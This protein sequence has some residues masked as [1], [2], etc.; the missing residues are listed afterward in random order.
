MTG[1]VESVTRLYGEGGVKDYCITPRMQSAEAEDI[2]NLAMTTNLRLLF[3]W[4]I[5]HYSSVHSLSNNCQK[6]L[7]HELF[8]FVDIQTLRGGGGGGD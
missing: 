6:K 7:L 5:T 1:Y 8:C 3:N 2:L 4:I